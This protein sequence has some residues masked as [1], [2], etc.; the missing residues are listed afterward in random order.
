M[1]RPCC[2]GFICVL[3]YLAGG[4]AATVAAAAAAA[5]VGRRPWLR[6]SRCRPAAAAAAV[7]RFWRRSVSERAGRVRGC[8][9]GSGPRTG[10]ASARRGYPDFCQLGAPPCLKQPD[11]PNYQRAT[12]GSA[13]QTPA[14]SPS[15][16]GKVGGGRRKGEGRGVALKAFH[17]H[18]EIGGELQPHL[19]P[20][21]TP[22][23]Q[24]TRKHKKREASALRDGWKDSAR[25]WE[26]AAKRGRGGEGVER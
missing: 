17:G 13:S 4:G 15:P 16:S 24:A 26:K 5:A 19:R 22:W 25:Q 11:S 7:H 12:S 21:L 6:H 23:Q 3:V 1:R 2:V 14:S 20:G 8:G 10:K 18:V 9:F